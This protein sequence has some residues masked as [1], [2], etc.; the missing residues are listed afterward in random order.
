M[1]L[2][3]IHYPKVKTWNFGEPLWVFDSNHCKRESKTD[4]AGHKRTKS[5][6]L[7]FMIQQLKKKKRYWETNEIWSGPHLTKLALGDPQTL[8]SNVHSGSE[9]ERYSNSKTYLF[10]ALIYSAGP[11]SKANQKIHLWF[12]TVLYLTAYYFTKLT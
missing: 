12:F 7:M 3:V 1:D 6:I 10:N 5:S 2:S 9:K 11:S 4:S 8:T